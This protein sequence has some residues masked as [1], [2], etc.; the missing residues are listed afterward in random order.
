[1]GIPPHRYQLKKLNVPRI[2]LY[3]AQKGRCSVT[4]EKLLPCGTSIVVTSNYGMKQRTI[5]TKTL[6]L[7]N[8]I[9][10]D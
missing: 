4:G 3:V 7:L 8:R 5:A 10:T 2:S 9:F 6:Q 1:M